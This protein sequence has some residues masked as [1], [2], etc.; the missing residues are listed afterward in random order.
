MM[1][2]S[3]L[4]ALPLFVGLWSR[5]RVRSLLEGLG[6]PSTGRWAS[7]RIAAFCLMLAFLAFG[8]AAAEP[9]LQREGEIP[10]RDDSEIILLY[11]ISRSMLAKPTPDG[12]TRL[13]RAQRLG[14]EI[15]R[16]LDDTPI[17]VSAFTDR[18]LPH[19]YPSTRSDYN[20]LNAVITRSV[21]VNNPP[22]FLDYAATEPLQPLIDIAGLGFFSSAKKENFV[23]VLTDGEFFESSYPRDL[24]NLRKSRLHIVF[25]QIR[26]PEEFIYD[27][28]GRLEPYYDSSRADLSLLRRYAKQLRASIIQEDKAVREVPRYIRSEQGPA[29]RPDDARPRDRELLL[30]PFLVLIGALSSGVFLRRRLFS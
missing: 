30:S 15:A 17:G 27:E 12:L 26:E 28:E 4:I 9:T 8:L 14:L 7:D 6:A 20:L 18:V 21:S 24:Q 29:V 22:P 13:E 10:K 23:V 19:L 3:L 16:A 1:Y 25:V 5:R 2:L 11:D